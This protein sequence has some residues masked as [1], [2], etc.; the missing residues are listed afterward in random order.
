MR[1]LR[2][3]LAAAS[4]DEREQAQPTPADDPR[5]RS[6]EQLS[7]A[8]AAINEFRGRVRSELRAHVARGGELAASG[9]DDIEA[10][11]RGASEAVARA[12]RG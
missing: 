5:S 6:R 12:M 4:R 8:D 2:A 7:R 11:L 3:D 10:A 1:S 9:V